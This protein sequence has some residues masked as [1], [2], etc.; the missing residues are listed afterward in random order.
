MGI[1]LVAWMTAG[2]AEAH[3]SYGGTARDLGTVTNAA[4]TPYFKT[5][6]TV[7][8]V[9]SDFGW[10]A[11]T[12]VSYGDAHHIRAYRFK[13]TDW[14]LA[15]IRIEVAVR[16][17]GAQVFLP[18]FSLYSGLLHTSGGSDYDTAPVTLAYLD[19]LGGK[20]GAF[21]A[22]GVMKIGND[23]GLLSTLNYVGNA[24]DGTS[25]NFGSAARIHGDGLADGVVEGTFWLPA[26]DYSVLVGG[27]NLA[28]M[29]STGRYGINA[30]LSAIPE[31]SSVALAVLGSVILMRRRG[32]DV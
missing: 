17:D 5:I 25:A 29:D 8:T 16:G 30:T 26:G 22:L 10:A 24:A 15:N 2:F 27:A 32:R 23:A 6:N 1:G 7:Q 3:T 31:T 9:T 19:S 14:S 20:N 28:G 11:G 18:G 21:N 4:V 12:G 13:L